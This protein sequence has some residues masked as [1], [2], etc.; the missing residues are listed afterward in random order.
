MKGSD[1]PVPFFRGKVS[2]FQSK[3]HKI[4]V[5]LV[6]F[7]SKVRGVKKSSKVADLG[8]GFGFLSIVLARKFGCKVYAVEKDPE[9]FHLLERNVELNSLQELVFPLFEDIKALPKRFRRGE[10]D[11][12]VTNPPF[13]PRVYGVEDGDVHFEGTTTLEDFLKVASYLLRD[14]GYLSLIVPSFRLVQSFEL[15][16][17]FN[18]PPR[19]LTVIYPTEKKEGRLCVISS[20]KNVP[21]P[22][23]IE[24]A[25]F[26]NKT[27]GGYTPEV[28][29]LLEGF[30]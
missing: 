23:R 20:R 11:V 7:L 2:F 26:I 29:A 15:L 25:L 18:M 6:V 1:K 14:G 19:F 30:L 16:N 5:D 24:K 21:G 13:F 8:A 10:F 28:E 17:T 12:V 3:K 9:L 22:L 27:E 4:S